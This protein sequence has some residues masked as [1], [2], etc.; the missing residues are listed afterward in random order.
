[1]HFDP[2]CWGS[3]KDGCCL[4]HIRHVSEEELQRHIHQVAQHIFTDEPEPMGEEVDLQKLFV[5]ILEKQDWTDRLA[6]G[7]G[8]IR[9]RITGP[10]GETKSSRKLRAVSNRPHGETKLPEQLR[11][12]ATRPH[13]DTNLPKELR[14]LVPDMREVEKAYAEMTSGY[15]DF[16]RDVVKANRLRRAA[17]YD[18]PSNE[19]S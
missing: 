15:K 18:R 17:R 2:E 9:N 10:R 3:S 19:G 11:T 5:R 12:K 7:L 14:S 6:S 4:N 1:L 13:W 8:K 16:I